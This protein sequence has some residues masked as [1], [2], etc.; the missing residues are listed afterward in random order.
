MQ[1]GNIQRNCVYHKSPIK[2]RAQL[3]ASCPEF[4][5]MN[6]IFIVSSIDIENKSIDMVFKR[7]YQRGIKI[8]IL[9]M[10]TIATIEFSQEYLPLNILD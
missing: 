4:L 2:L 10:K 7:I 6:N 9:K 8:K 1:L 3:A 5:V